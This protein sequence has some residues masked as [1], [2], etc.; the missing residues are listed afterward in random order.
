MQVFVEN[1]LLQQMNS[2]FN[3]NAP[4]NILNALQ[5]GF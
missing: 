1:K 5:K 3:I 4:K 2:D